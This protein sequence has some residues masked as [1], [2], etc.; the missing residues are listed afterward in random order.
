MNHVENFIKEKKCQ[1]II[2]TEPLPPEFDDILSK[3]V[4]LTTENDQ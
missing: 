1:T 2:Q 3:R 4:Q